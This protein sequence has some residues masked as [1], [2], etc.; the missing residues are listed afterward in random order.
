MFGFQAIRPPNPKIIAI[1][2]AVFVATIV[3]HQVSFLYD[4]IFAEGLSG[5][6]D[7]LTTCQQHKPTL[8]HLDSSQSRKKTTIPNIIHQIWK[9]SNVSEYSKDPSYRSWKAVYEPRKYTV[10]LWTDDEIHELIKVKYPSLLP[11]YES[12]PH[13]IQRAD[14]ARLV[15][16]HSEGGI[17]ADLDVYP[18]A[19][20][21]LQC[22]QNL[23]VQAIFGPTVGT[24][25][26]SNHFFM[27]EKGSPFL[28]WALDEAKRRAGANSN[29]IVLPY[30]RVFWSTGPMMVTAAALEYAEL[31]GAA[32]H[33]LAILDDHYVRKVVGHL[34]GRSWHGPD[35]QFLNFVADYHV[36]IEKIALGLGVLVLFVLAAVM[37][38]L[39]YLKRR[40]TNR[41]PLYIDVSQQKLYVH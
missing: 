3:I 30:L 23:G 28:R 27:A 24:T 34:G 18:R 22:L 16:V 25:G 21:E 33:R 10:K 26:V 32:N 41:R 9:S 19:V 37:A 12:Y 13:N 6:L 39:V 36:V 38:R 8:K 15:V 40:Q 31:Q 7:V 14:M 11:T 2:G 4:F 17:Y 29:Q 35:G 5:P 1:I 20:G